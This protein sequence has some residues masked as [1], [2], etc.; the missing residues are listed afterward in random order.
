MMPLMGWLPESTP[1]MDMPRT[2]SMNSSGEP[3]ASTSG[4]AMGM[5]RVRTAAPIK[6]PINEAVKAAPRARAAS[7][8][9]ARG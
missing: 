4:R 5:M 3:K 2:A 9:R 6:P 8:L 1:T 7:P